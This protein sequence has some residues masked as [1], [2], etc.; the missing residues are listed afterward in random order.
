VGTEPV[1]PAKEM[2]ERFATLA[3]RT[4]LDDLAY[5]IS[6]ADLFIG[7][8]SSGMHLAS[9]WDVPAL[10][11]FGGYES[12]AGYD[13]ANVHPL[14]SPVPCAPCWRQSCPYE[15][16]CLHAIQPE[17]VIEQALRL[18]ERSRSPAGQAD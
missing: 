11:I 18:L 6:Q 8:S 3:G 14:Y 17:M 13:Y 4:S 7:P 12:P 2:G 1:L 16:K 10:I 9:A 5:V 15:L